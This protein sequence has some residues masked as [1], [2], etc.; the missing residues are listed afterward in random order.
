MPGANIDLLLVGVSHKTAPVAVRER[1]AVDPDAVA[2]AL[3]ELTGLAQV[4]EAVMLAT[5]N[6]VELYVAADDADRAAAG[7]A[8]VLARRAGVQVADLAEHLYQHRD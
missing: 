7:L 3:A 1:L 5:C 6:R 4:R 8:E 2:A